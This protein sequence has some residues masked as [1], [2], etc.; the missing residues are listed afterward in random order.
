MKNEISGNGKKCQ[1]DTRS[2]TKR[3]AGDS[4]TPV[5]T[6]IIVSYNTCNLLVKCIESIYQY[7]ENFR[8]QIIVVDNASSDGTIEVLEKKFSEIELIKNS[9][10]V[11]FATANNQALEYIRGDYVLFLNSDV[12]FMSPVFRTVEDFFVDHPDAG[13]VGCKLINLNGRVQ[14]SFS[15]NLPSLFNRFLDVFYFEKMWNLIS[16]D[17]ESIITPIEVASVDGACMFLKKDLVKKLMGFDT[18]FFMYC[19]DVDLCYRVAQTGYKVFYL[20]QCLMFHFHGASS[21]KNKRTYFAKV[22]TTASVYYYFNKHYNRFAAEMYR[23]IMGMG[24]CFRCLL[25]IIFSPF[26]WLLQPW[27]R[28]TLQKSLLKYWKVI[29]WSVG[30]ETWVRNPF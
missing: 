17:Y 22:L 20:G 11:G 9:I 15:Y 25:L 16:D 30:F 23:L 24:S 3:R 2:S 8:L 13:L 12:L 27:S 19:E 21:Q 14:K 7:R 26:I 4:Q 18:H 6:I 1:M 10:N 28:I 5:F 29:S